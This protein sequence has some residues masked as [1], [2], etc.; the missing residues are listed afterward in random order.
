MEL[1]G[2]IFLQIFIFLLLLFW[3]SPSFFAPLLRLF[4]E[5]ERRIIGA[6]R[7]ALELS[8]RANEKSRTFD[9]E[10]NKAKDE[11]RHTLS[12]LKQ[13][14]EKEHSEMMQRAKNTAR[15][16][17]ENAGRALG[18]QERRIKEELK[19]TSKMIADDVVNALVRHRV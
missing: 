10:Y 17:L 16:R 18:E 11:A 5:R 4:D 6:Q 14:M 1:N 9:S 2:T 3:L 15:E 8:E 13:A 19:A 7:E 12:S